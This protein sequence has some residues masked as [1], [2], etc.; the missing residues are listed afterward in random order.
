[1]FALTT[2]DLSDTI[3]DCAVG[4]ASS[5]AELSA[6]RGARNLA[7]EADLLTWCALLP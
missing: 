6:D 3:L 1:M 4:P 2:E 7:V 5:N